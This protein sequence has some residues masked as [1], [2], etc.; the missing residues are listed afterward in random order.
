[1]VTT[2]RRSCEGTFLYLKT[3]KFQADAG[4]VSDKTS[5]D[6][7]P[8]LG[9]DKKTCVILVFGDASIEI[10]VVDLFYLVF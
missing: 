3:T 2:L 7:C 1:M 4:V 5:H 10:V 8:S 6:S 9:H